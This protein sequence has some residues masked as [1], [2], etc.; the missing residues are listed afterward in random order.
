MSP[1]LKCHQNWIVTKTE[2][3]PNLKF[4]QN[5]DFTK[6]KISFK[7]KWYQNWN[8]TKHNNILKINIKIQEIGT[9]YTGLVWF[10]NKFKF[11]WNC[12]K[13]NPQF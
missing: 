11:W 13:K 4:H 6:T 9:D 2:M 8:V 1:E 5:S 10:Q 7:L 12:H 3:L